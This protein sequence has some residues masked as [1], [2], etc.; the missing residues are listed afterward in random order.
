MYHAR[1]M[2]L[3]RLL[4][5]HRG[6]LSAEEYSNYGKMYQ[7]FQRLHNVYETE[8]DNFPRIMEYMQDL[9]ECG[10]PPADIIKDLAPGLDF[11]PDG[12]PMLPN[13]GQGLPG[14]PHLPTGACSIM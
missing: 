7:T 3:S 14:M 9:Q 12:M 8:P 5:P 6:K 2:C 10:Q 13:M 1:C 4:R 11:G